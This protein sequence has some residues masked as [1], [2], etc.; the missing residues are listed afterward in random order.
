[1]R[2]HESAGFGP[3]GRERTCVV[4]DVHIKPVFHAVVAHE[5]ED[6]VVDVAEEVDL[7]CVSIEARLCWQVGSQEEYIW[8]DPPVIV[9]FH[10]SWVAIEEPAVP[11]THMSVRDH[12]T[13]TNADG[14]EVFET[15]HEATFVN[16]FGQGPMFFGYR[17]VVA[18]R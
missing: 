13:L 18:M 11:A 6:V 7:A 8:F 12:I 15:V 2:V 1:M 14:V 10:Q 4:E 5:A 9:K 16:P 17:F 3:E